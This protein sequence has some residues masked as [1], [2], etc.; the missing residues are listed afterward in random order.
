MRT[1][2]E[3]PSETLEATAYP[4]IGHY[5]GG[6]WIYDRDPCA[7]ILNPSTE[8]VMGTVPNATD[9]DIERVL[10][11]AEKG[12]HIW[13]DTPPR[14][15]V[16]IILKAVA[17]MR[18]RTT[19]IAA[20][21]SLENGKTKAQGIGEV[22]R[23]IDFYE[24]EAGQ[25]LR[26]YGTIVPAE[27][28]FQKMLVRQP[29]GPVIALTP[30]NVPMS[31]IARKSSAALAAGC[32]VIAKPAQETPGTAIAI[33]KCFEDAGLPPG[34]FNL[35]YGP[36][37]RI[38]S[39]LIASPVTRLVTFTG[40]TPIGKILM[41]QA[42]RA[43]IPVLME[44]GGNA[45]VIVCDDVDAANVGRLSAEAKSRGAGQICASV[46]R[47]I[48]HRD[49]YDSFV[50]AFAD[51][52]NGI[53]VGDMFADGVQMGP[54]TNARRLASTQ[55]MVE[56]ARKRG[57]TV[58]AGGYRIGERGY[59]HAPT[60]LADI[61]LDAEAMAE[62]PFAPIAA[63]VPFSTLDEALSIAN[64]V[65]VGL[66][67]YAFTNSLANAE[68]IGRRLENGVV[69]INHFDTPHADTPFG[70]VKDTGI[71]REGGPFSL[72]AYLQTKT[73]LLNSARV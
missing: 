7:E 13:R 45:P 18:E 3:F 52:L 67:S 61:P 55:H 40:S 5:I 66:A 25:A 8:N 17:L 24:W 16:D 41:E 56:D 15:R 26:A 68:E 12:F 71:G 43:M 65:S 50:S 23:S 57:A 2:T 44:L 46:S 10:A 28:G 21:L 22:T 62:E 60:L 64:S 72:D 4:R 33:V 29:I 70:G 49:C 48:V 30:W 58:A 31:A 47:F 14:Q 38:S 54:V 35:I 51:T 9:E 19:E 63:C 39:A 73:I 1:I 36:S 59:F 37:A 27:N 34:V 20:I 53:K 42:G 32:S 69:S 11:A 6:E